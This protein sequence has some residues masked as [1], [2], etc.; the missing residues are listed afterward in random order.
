MAVWYRGYCTRFTQA[1]LR[2]VH[3]SLCSRDRG[4]WVVDASGLKQADFFGKSDPYAKVRTMISTNQCACRSR[5]K[6]GNVHRINYPDRHWPLSRY[7]ASS[8]DVFGFVLMFHSALAVRNLLLRK[9]IALANKR[10]P[11]SSGAF[12]ASLPFANSSMSPAYSP[13]QVFLDPLS[14][15]QF[16]HPCALVAREPFVLPER[17]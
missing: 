11:R 15:P 1:I 7:P 16:G 3:R 12:I 10:T 14:V 5:D 8:T 9:P 4:L 13:V 6:F 2:A 17:S